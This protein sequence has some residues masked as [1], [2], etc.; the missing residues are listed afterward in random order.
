MRI[1]QECFIFK[2]DFENAYDSMDWGFVEYIM[3]RFAFCN[4]WVRWMK[5]CVFWENMSI[6]VNGSPND[7]IVFKG[8]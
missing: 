7:E 3:K 8:D 1:K 2:V 5:A 4:K 6:L